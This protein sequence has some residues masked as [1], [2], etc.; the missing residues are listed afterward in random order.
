[1]TIPLG[2]YFLTPIVLVIINRARLNVG[3]QWFLAL[4]AAALAWLM[5]VFSYLRLPLEVALPF[6]QL[7]SYQD[8]VPVLLLD[9]VSWSYAVAVAT[10]AL[11]VLLTDAARTRWFKPMSWASS[12]AFTG[13]GLLA[14]LA[15]NPMILLP[16]WA[17][18]DLI[19]TWILLNLVSSSAH[20]ERVVVVFTIRLA[21]IFLLLLAVMRAHFQGFT[22]AFDAIPPEVGGYLL[23]AVLTKPFSKSHA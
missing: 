18:L 6:W 19:E 1:M 11:A 3:Y 20:R 9:S 13:F 2:L 10:L 7:G 21:G 15:K 16:A 5:L 22:L 14:I 4:G 12:L 23:L 17:A 8:D